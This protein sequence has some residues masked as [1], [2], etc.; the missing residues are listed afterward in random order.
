MGGGSA[1][2][3]AA[4]RGADSILAEQAVF[5]SVRSPMGEGYRIIAASTGVRPDEK[6]EITRRAPSHAGLCSTDQ[7]AA[8][9]LGFPLKNGR[10]CLGHTYYAGREH[11]ARGGQRVYS[12]FVV[13]EQSAWRAFGC[14]AIRLDAALKHAAETPFL[15]PGRSIGRLVLA[16]SRVEGSVRRNLELDHSRWTRPPGRIEHIVRIC[17]TI[18]CGEQLL[19]AGRDD[20]WSLLHL[21]LVSLP[22]SARRL[23]GVSVGICF[24]PARGLQLCVVPHDPDISER[25]VCGR[26]MRC[27]SLDEPCAQQPSPFDPWLDFVKGLLRQGR[28]LQLEKLTSTMMEPV[29]AEEL[30]DVAARFRSDDARTET[31]A[32]HQSLDGCP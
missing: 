12:H 10:H 24:S 5:T 23:L 16:P 8:G 25:A 4:S 19:V 3:T 1:L 20:S 27:L 21:C 13:L 6:A 9:L 17:R 18:L 14:N 32:S 31:A 11:T 29:S 15:K 22:Q 28:I 26:K 2:E 7:A 30:A